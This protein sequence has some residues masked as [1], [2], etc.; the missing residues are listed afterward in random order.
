MN[1]Q[2]G[3]L[4]YCIFFI[5]RT[6]ERDGGKKGQKREANIFGL[7]DCFKTTDSRGPLIFVHLSSH[8][9]SYISIFLNLCDV[10][11]ISI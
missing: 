8:V 9:F 4:F 1:R 6:N 7:F 10:H 5:Y 11:Y 3:D 2:F